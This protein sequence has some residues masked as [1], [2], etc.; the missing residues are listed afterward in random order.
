MR[1]VTDNLPGLHWHPDGYAALGGPLL[2]LATALDAV[3][4]SWAADLGAQ[5]ERFPSFIALEDLKPL[6]YLRSFPQLATFA[7]SLKPEDEALRAFSQRHAAAEEITVEADWSS[8][9][10]VLTP[11]ACY[12][13]YHRL[14]DQR[15]EHA[16]YLTTCCTC[17][18][19]EEHYEPLARQ[20]CF[21]M[22]E[23]VCIGD[24]DAVESFIG[25]CRERIE[26]LVNRL[27][28]AT[29]WETAHD[30]FFD[31][32]NDP[33]ALAQLLEPMKSE[34][35]FGDDLAI[36]STNR[37]RSFFGECYGIRH[38]ERPAVSACVAFGLERWL[39]AIV[40]THGQNPDSWPAI[41]EWVE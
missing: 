39:L 28:L 14:A 22:R 11:A 1:S 41:A 4:V 35:V 31:P 33:K 18:R 13:F 32:R 26:H 37:H 9:R 2:Q 27:G 34:L 15:L 36:G 40:S 38:G 21:Q 12:H 23:L 29:R 3:F 5:E 6:E 19:R 17:H 25:Y 10:Q 7:L 24:D 8:V 20:W 16:L 30:P